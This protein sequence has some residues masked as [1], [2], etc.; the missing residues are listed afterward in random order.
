MTEKPTHKNPILL[1]F[2]VFFAVLACLFGLQLRSALAGFDRWVGHDDH[3]LPNVRLVDKNCRFVVINRFIELQPVQNADA[4]I[5]GDS[6]IF[7]RG[8][9]SEQMFYR[10]WLGEDAVVINFSFLAAPISDLNAMARNLE[11]RG[12]KAK[13]SLLVVNIS[14]YIG[15]DISEKNYLS[16]EREQTILLPGPSSSVKRLYQNRALC[17]FRMRREF[18]RDN[19]RTP[20]Y[21]KLLDTFKYLPLRD[22]FLDYDPVDFNRHVTGRLEI[23]SKISDD[24]IVMTAPVAYDKL[25]HY[26]FDPAKLD[27]FSKSFQNI[28]APLEGTI[29]CID[30]MQSMTS[31]GFMDLIHMNA[32][33]HEMLGKNLKKELEN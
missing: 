3:R 32:R 25:D 23:L 17:A 2:L 33:G 5:F 28:C 29:T 31:E 12:F 24:G 11:A 7:A 27:A 1:A 16:K 4:Y 30:L 9:T 15:E 10:H 18:S 21:R 14:H 20:R 8:A 22:N 26:K 19:L 6:Q 13:K